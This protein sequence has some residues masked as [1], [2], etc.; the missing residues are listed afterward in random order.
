MRPE[1]R[2]AS[3]DW[4]TE[5]NGNVLATCWTEVGVDTGRIH[6]AWI[7]LDPNLQGKTKLVVRLV[8]FHEL[9]HCIMG[10]DHVDDEGDLMAPLIP[11]DM[12]D[13]LAELRIETYMDRLAAGKR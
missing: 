11:V 9:G 8:L 2:I 10:S 1:D 4:R 12:D 3:I 13:Q 6:R 5:S 7:E